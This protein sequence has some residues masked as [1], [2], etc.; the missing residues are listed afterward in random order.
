MKKYANLFIAICAWSLISVFGLVM[1][2]CTAFDDRESN[3]V[4]VHIAVNQAVVRYVD[5]NGDFAGREAR[6]VEL[7]SVLSVTR[8]YIEGNAQTSV[9]ALLDVFAAQIEWERLS[10]ADQMLA[11]SVI[12]LVKV[13]LL[14]LVG[15][16][17]LPAN[18]VLYLRDVID[19]AIDAARYL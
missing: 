14:K 10:V 16:G 8:D 11:V 15:G 3:A 9:D 12:E 7:L 19:T 1:G 17:E 13:E 18:T 6:R 4:V 5:G 2:G